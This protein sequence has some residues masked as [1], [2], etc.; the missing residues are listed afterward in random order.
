MSDNDSV[1]CLF[2]L[3]RT[4]QPVVDIEEG[5]L[6][7]PRRP[8][9]PSTENDGQLSVQPPQT[10][11]GTSVAQAQETSSADDEWVPAAEPP[12][13]ISDMSVEETQ[14]RK[15]SSPTRSSKQPPKK[16]LKPLT[17]KQR[18]N[19]ATQWIVALVNESLH[20]R[21]EVEKLP[22]LY[23]ERFGEKLPDEPVALITS[24]HGQHQLT[25][26]AEREKAYV[27]A[28]RTLLILN[29]VYR[30]VRASSNRC[31]EL[32]QLLA[33]YKEEYKG[34]RHAKLKKDDCLC[35][36]EKQTFAF[37]GVRSHEG[38]HLVTCKSSPTLFN[39]SAQ[40]VDLVAKSTA[41]TIQKDKGFV[42]F[43][44]H[45]QKLGN[46][47]LEEVSRDPLIVDRIMEL[48]EDHG[49]RKL[50]VQAVLN[51]CPNIEVHE[52]T[53][54][55]SIRVRY[56]PEA[57][58]ATAGCLHTVPEN[59]PEGAA[60]EQPRPLLA[61]IAM[62]WLYDVLYQSKG[63]QIPWP[64]L[65]ER[66]VVEQ[67]IC[68]VFFLEQSQHAFACFVESVAVLTKNYK[69]QW[70]V[71][72]NDEIAQTVLGYEATDSV[73]ELEEGEELDV[74][75]DEEESTL[76]PYWSPEEFE[77]RL[78]VATNYYNRYGMEKLIMN[79]KKIYKE[80][81]EWHKLGISKTPGPNQW[82]QV[83]ALIN[84]FKYLKAETKSSKC[85]VVSRY[86]SQE[87]KSIVAEHLP[88]SKK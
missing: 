18:N 3:D 63:C 77:L 49:V 59:V 51:R 10:I 4:G 6:Q 46:S 74:E 11:S 57:P 80:E 24:D 21:L 37:L 67:P 7:D 50:T 19:Q 65:A 30:F 36:L 38:K 76:L 17:K 39:P 35:M 42:Y 41:Q 60:V 9:L 58:P 68:S 81:I 13:Q 56:R 29:R 25:I 64:E 40:L 43:M 73:G 86:S 53:R 16:K 34:Q 83:A 82:G 62:E 79:Y 8:N 1:E 69:N 75:N 70:F 72:P 5:E 78:I 20:E 28:A 88:K 33:H 54:T 66:F 26:R 44:K 45:L 15:R 85:V 61:H 12:E 55:R 32:D 48:G 22:A 2:V 84:S 23:L 71:R 47:P 87:M 31:V 14:A 52:N 27:Y